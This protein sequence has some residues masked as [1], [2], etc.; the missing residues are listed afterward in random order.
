MD[1]PQASAALPAIRV[2]VHGIKGSR[3][4]MVLKSG[5]VLHGQGQEFTPIVEAVLREGAALP[6]YEL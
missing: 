5:L 3:A 4:P 6:G 2:L 1:D